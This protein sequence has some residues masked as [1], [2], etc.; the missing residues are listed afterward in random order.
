[1]GDGRFV[2]PKTLEVRLQRRRHARAEGR[3]RV[4]QPRDACDDP[5]DPRPRGRPAADAHRSARTRPAAR[6]PDRARRRLRRPGVRAGVPPL[7]QPRDGRRARASAARPRG[8]GRRGRHRADSSATRG[9]TSSFRPRCS[10][11]RADP[12]RACASACGRLRASGLIEGSDILVAAGRTP[13]TAGI[14]LETAGVELDERGYVQVNDRLETTAPDV[15]AIGECA[16]SPQFTHVSYDDFRVVRDNLAGGN[17]SDARPADP[18]LP[19]HRPAAGAG[20]P[21]RSAKP[22]ASGV[23]VRVAKMP[24]SAVLRTRTIGE[25]AAS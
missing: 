23:A 6:A 13:N 20:R 3:A 2:A 8:P 4:P 15:W 16:G 24:M 22:G 12:A 19:V 18:V 10:R 14:G 21:E 9:S 1:M 5:G 7:R 11:S 25:S 17:R